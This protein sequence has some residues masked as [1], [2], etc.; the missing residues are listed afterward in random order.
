MDFSG[1]SLIKLK[2]EEMETQVLFGFFGKTGE[3][4]RRF[5]GKYKIEAGL[6]VP[7]VTLTQEPTAP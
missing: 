4:L 6:I 5:L 3:V 1:M 7:K 2:M